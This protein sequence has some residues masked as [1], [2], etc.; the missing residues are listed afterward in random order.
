MCTAIAVGNPFT[1]RRP[2]A[3]LVVTSCSPRRAR[4]GFASRYVH[5]G[6]KLI[7]WV[8][9]ATLIRRNHSTKDC[10]QIKDVASNEQQTQFGLIWCKTF[11]VPWYV[12]QISLRT[13]TMFTD[14]VSREFSKKPIGFTINE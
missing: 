13:L 10:E 12:A 8:G 11:D 14:L 5:C 4:E 3:T 7:V 9:D 2:L 6:R 1:D